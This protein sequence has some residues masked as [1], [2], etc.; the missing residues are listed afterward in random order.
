MTRFRPLLENG[1]QAGSQVTSFLE[2]T[3]W[4]KHRIFNMTTTQRRMAKGA[5]GA[6]TECDNWLA[7]S[8]SGLFLKI[9]GEPYL[10]LARLTRASVGLKGQTDAVNCTATR[11]DVPDDGTHGTALLMIGIIWPTRGEREGRPAAPK[12]AGKCP[13]TRLCCLCSALAFSSPQQPDQPFLFGVTVG[14]QL[15]PRYRSEPL[16]PTGRRFAYAR[17]KSPARPVS[18]ASKPSGLVEERP[19]KLHPA[20]TTCYYRRLSALRSVACYSV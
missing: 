5:I 17:L 15:S 10:G 2:N 18:I 14:M 11:Y 12:R 9:A 16:F 20:P 1:Q 7:A 13:D 6:M 3:P 4:S 19:T 8:Q